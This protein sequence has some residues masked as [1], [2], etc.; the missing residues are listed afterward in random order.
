[1]DNDEIIS[2]GETISADL[3]PEA[4]FTTNN[5]S[6]YWN[7]SSLAFIS[8][9]DIYGN[10]LYL[11]SWDKVKYFDFYKE[12]IGS[13]S[14][15]SK[16]LNYISLV[17][18]SFNS[19]V[20]L[21][22]Q[23]GSMHSRYAFTS[24]YASG[25][26]V[27]YLESLEEAYVI[28]HVNSYDSVGKLNLTSS[29]ITYM[30]TS[31][32]FE[33][34][35]FTTD[36]AY[37]INKSLYLYYSFAQGYDTQELISGILR[38]NTQENKIRTSYTINGTFTGYIEYS[39]S[40]DHPTEINTRYYGIIARNHNDTKSEVYVSILKEIDTDQL[41]STFSTIKSFSVSGPLSTVT[42][43]TTG[44]YIDLAANSVAISILEG[45]SLSVIGVINFNQTGTIQKTFQLIYGAQ[46]GMQ[47]T[48]T[49]F[50]FKTLT[51]GLLSGYIFRSTNPAFPLIQDVGV[52]ITIP[53]P[54]YFQ[55]GTPETR[56][57]TV[58]DETKYIKNSNNHQ[59]AYP[60][61]I[62]PWI[63]VYNSSEPYYFTAS[64]T[65]KM[66]Q[67][68]SIVDRHLL[69]PTTVPTY[70]TQYLGD[71][72]KV[73]LFDN[74]T[75]DQSICEDTEYTQYIQSLDGSSLNSKFTFIGS[76]NTL[77]IA[78]SNDINVVGVYD[79]KFKCRIQDG[80]SNETTFQ[81]E[82]LYDGR[83]LPG[84][85]YTTTNT[86]TNSSSNNNSTTNQTTNN[87]TVNNNSS[88]NYNLAPMFYTKIQGF[89]VRAGS[90]AVLYLPD[91][92]DPNGD[93]VTISAKQNG[94]YKGEYFKFLDNNKMEFN[95]GLKQLGDQDITII[96]TDNNINPLSTKYRI[97]VTVLQSD[98]IQMNN[99]DVVK[100][101]LSDIISIQDTS[102][103][104]VQ[105]ITPT[106]LVTIKF[107]KPLNSTN[108]T[109]LMQE[110]YESLRL[111][112]DDQSILFNWTVVYAKDN[113]L[114]IKIDFSNPL[115]VKSQG[116]DKTQL[117]IILTNPSLFLYTNTNKSMSYSTYVPPQLSDYDGDFVKRIA[118]FFNNTFSSI[119]ITQST[120]DI[121]D[122]DAYN[123]NFR[124]FGYDSKIA[125]Q[126]MG[127]NTFLL[128]VSPILILI[129]AILQQ[130]AI[131][132]PK[133]WSFYI[134][135]YFTDFVYK[136]WSTAYYS[137]YFIRR[138]IFVLS[139]LFFTDSPYL[140]L[141]TFQLLS[142]GQF[143]YL[144]TVMPFETKTNN[145]MEFINEGLVLFTAEI[146]ILFTDYEPNPEHRYILGWVVLS[147]IIFVS[148]IN[149]SLFFYQ[150][151]KTIKKIAR[152]VGTK[153]KSLIQKFRAMRKSS[154]SPS[155]ISLTSTNQSLMK[156]SETN[157]NFM[158]KTTQESS[159]KTIL[160]KSSQ[161]NIEKLRSQK[162]TRNYIDNS[163]TV[164][165][166][167]IDQFKSGQ[168]TLRQNTIQKLKIS[169]IRSVYLKNEYHRQ[170]VSKNIDV[171]SITD[172]E[173]SKQ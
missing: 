17:Q 121:P 16:D 85:N 134:Q 104:K 18:N 79:L 142:I 120:F 130:F 171:Q 149:M 109:E 117:R 143:I 161:Q 158:T 4:N 7:V 63:T 28:Q 114:Q 95:A 129:T 6:N 166:D 3:F 44:V 5:Y 66:A 146:L 53:K 170:N 115:A 145:V 48:F 163:K 144:I 156:L 139:M 51:T 138:F 71:N 154:S 56:S 157:S 54:Y 74:C 108:Q 14:T 162:K 1:M 140:Q 169:T 36:I 68:I 164:R 35:G 93:E 119:L 148:L 135:Y 52:L 173:D 2:I 38:F 98:L 49:Y 150:A 10:I 12:L 128:L 155:T 153:L 102:K 111:Q 19:L 89:T 91:F 168:D 27:F 81:V 9:T 103:F 58:L 72:V 47:L 45:S 131:I 113:V 15:V 21:N 75:Y 107:E 61:P 50:R 80:L 62:N 41:Q 59:I 30:L 172:D 92:F 11:K 67:P 34:S 65:S 160:N 90:R 8:R 152:L 116:I 105:Q 24:Y 77:Y 147:A 88:S 43:L 151:I 97:I 106:G 167:P 33:G 141:L 40:Q 78:K 25:I 87:Q 101:N 26:Q 118:E 29:P 126:N 73:V 69:L 83:S 23:D 60:M 20:I 125:F 133:D 94:A 100:S 42:S 84:L 46:L 124:D 122:Q 64:V 86:T 110:I 112:I 159:I 57:V 32:E 96:L 123:D 39:D 31:I 99:T 76:T 55:M 132:V 22:T 127:F 165:I 82:Y 137:L 136:K 70:I 37:L 13:T